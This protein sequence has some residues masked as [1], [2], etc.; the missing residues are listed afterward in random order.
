[1]LTSDRLSL[2]AMSLVAMNKYCEGLLN[3]FRRVSV[4]PC[5]GNRTLHFL[6][7]CQTINNTMLDQKHDETV[8]KV[9]YRHCHGMAQRLS[10]TCRSSS[11]LEL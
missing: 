10:C 11:S 4:A 1:M 5:D 8:D 3:T 9:S 7:S 2:V 6:A